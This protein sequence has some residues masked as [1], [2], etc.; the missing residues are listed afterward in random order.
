[1]SFKSL[2]LFK[3]NKLYNLYSYIS[4][5]FCVYLVN[6]YNRAISYTSCSILFENRGEKK[7]KKKRS[8][9]KARKTSDNSSV[10]EISF[11]LLQWLFLGADAN[12][13]GICI[14]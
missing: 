6:H 5:F 9:I 14:L 4:E 11:F 7:K 2:F 1:M 12:H 10:F 3:S 13:G 8:E